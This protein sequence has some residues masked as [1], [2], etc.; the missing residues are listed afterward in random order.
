MLST[1]CREAVWDCV[2]VGGG[3][4]GIAAATY[5]ADAGLRV[6]LLEKRP[7][8]GGRASSFANSK[9]GELVDVCQHI[10]LG[11]C[12]VFDSLLRRLGV[13]DRIR[14]LEKIDFS[15]PDGKRFELRSSPL[16]APYHLLPSLLTFPGLS[17]RD[18]TSLAKLM[19]TTLRWARSASGKWA[20]EAPQSFG[21]ACR[22][23]GLARRASDRLIS[24]TIV[25]AC[26]ASPDEVDASYGFMVLYEVLCSTR[27]GYRIGVPS[28]PLAS[29][30][31]EPTCAFL[32]KRGSAVA[33]RTTVE[34][35]QADGSERVVVRLKSGESVAARQCVVAVP[36]YAVRMLLRE[37][38]LTEHQLACQ[39]ALRPSPI[40][41][42]HY[43]FRNR[44]NCPPAVC[45][46]GAT[47]HWVFNVQL[48]H[49]LNTGLGHLSAVVSADSRLASMPPEEVALTV[50]R[51]IEDRLPE[52][53]GQEVLVWRCAREQRGTFIPHP[54]V[55]AVR[56]G[57]QTRQPNILL[58]GDWIATGWPSTMEGAARSGLLTAR[59]L[60]VANA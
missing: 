45:L 30:F 27:S 16:P 14:Y 18:R 38:L 42:V 20:D 21:E 52:I 34:H 9:T 25:S 12:T 32:E 40:V 29:I 7:Y 36:W 8:L 11:C 49:G 46:I 31:T 33:V 43:W 60:L 24:P 15:L 57:P 35:V 55:D 51:D 47:T 44:V 26:N 23:A 54:G 5:L 58:A 22:R 48:N 41:G 2:V 59:H 1:A 53:R 3:V 37:D 10:S 4:A 39:A 13:E 28:E 56:P 19:G 17:F 6:L 50:R